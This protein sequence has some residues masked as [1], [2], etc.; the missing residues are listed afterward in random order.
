MISFSL[1]QIT[2]MV[3]AIV[4][5]EII[6]VKILTLVVMVTILTLVVMG[7]ILILVVMDI[8][9]I[10]ML[11]GTVMFV[12]TGVN[13]MILLMKQDHVHEHQ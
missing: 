2:Q 9:L 11:V 3:L 10:V 13:V 8:N 1:L 12:H 6:Q 5:V 7:T 4:Q